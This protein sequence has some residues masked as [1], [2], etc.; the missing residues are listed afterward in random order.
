MKEDNSNEVGSNSEPKPNK[1][2]DSL[3]CFE[4]DDWRSL[5]QSDPQAFELKREEWINHLIN[6]AP[7]QYQK[8]LNGIKFHLD[9]IRATES[10]A[11]QTCIKAS[12][13]MMDSLAD[14]GS[15]LE[16][17]KFTLTGG[18]D[19]SQLEKQTA[20]ILQFVRG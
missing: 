8:R 6:E 12:S 20:D 15:F 3:P 10:C 4:F 13:M 14:M 19:Q 9:G 5:H 18:V 1:A 16:E 11:M 17:L 7:E 2:L